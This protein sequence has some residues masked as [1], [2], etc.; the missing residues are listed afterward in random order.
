MTVTAAEYS[1]P[2]TKS[3][4]PSGRVIV[5]GSKG[6][7]FTVAGVIIEMDHP[8]DGGSSLLTITKDA[9]KKEIA[10][11]D[12]VTYT[13]TIEN[14]KAIDTT[15]VYIEDKIPAG[16]KYIEGKATLDGAAIS[17]PTG[18]RPL[19]F[20][21]GTVSANTTET[22]KYQLV[23]GSGVTFGNYENTTFA[24]YSNGDAISNTAS[25]TVKVIPEVLFDLGTIIGKVFCDKNE[26]GIQDKGE[27]PIPKVQIVT[28]TG[29]VITTDKQ[30]KYHLAGIIPGRHLLRIDETTLPK[31]AYLTTDKAVIVDITEGLL[32][33]VNFGVKLPDE[34]ALEDMPFKIT[35]NRNLPVCRLN[36]SL[37]NDELIIKDNQLRQQAEFRIF[38]NYHLFIDTW[39][40]NILDQDTDYVIKSF[41]GTQNNIF[42]PIYWQGKDSQGRLIR[43]ERNYAYQLIVID[44]SGRSDLTR[45]RTLKVKNYDYF[46]ILEEK[47]EPE[48]ETEDQ[49]QQWLKEEAKVSNLEKQRIPIRGE[50]IMVSGEYVSFKDITINKNEKNSD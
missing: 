1:Y 8:L 46:S 28:E 45:K 19:T 9:N 29:A 30:G 26:N 40:L 21:I 43:P 15:S 11:G 22:L 3:S 17:D 35:R 34:T 38:T 33:K 7:T 16:F 50:A 37:F 23:V 39:Y 20:D 4:F 14:S 41:K 48:Q 24:K 2:S 6:E 18:N 25:E 5:D 32:A 27:E 12:I 13:V 42:E 44:P 47:P 31:G 36:V 10:V 49:Y